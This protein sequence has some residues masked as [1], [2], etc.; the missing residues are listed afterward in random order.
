MQKILPLGEFRSSLHEGRE[1]RYDHA[2]QDKHPDKHDGL[3][4]IQFAFAP[5]DDVVDHATHHQADRNEV[6]EQ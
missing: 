1:G 6:Q 5:D 4:R 3:H 2:R